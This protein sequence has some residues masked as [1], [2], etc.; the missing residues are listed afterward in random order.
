MLLI[1]D[2]CLRKIIAA[3]APLLFLDYDGTLVGLQ[4]R[5]EGAI[6]RPAKRKLLSELARKIPLAFVSGRS[7]A[8]L[9]EVV[10]IEGVG[11]IGNHGLEIRCLEKDW[12]HP[13]AKSIEP[14]LRDFLKLLMKKAKGL[15]G[16]LLENKGLSGSVHFRC[17]PGGQTRML[18]NLVRSEIEKHS[19]SLRLVS[20]KKVLDVLP[21]VPWDKGRAIIKYI[22][23]LGIHE[24]ITKVYIGDDRTDEDAFK[25]LNSQDIG[26]AVGNRKKT[27]ARFRR[28]DIQGVWNLLFSLNSLL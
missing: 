8:G 14:E 22:S 2:E 27:A 5:P 4:P 17:T 7:L 18:R 9:A 16:V 20:N 3:R 28:R 1:M 11:Y 19:R 21:Q 6:L 23:C 12:V 10:A 15:D 13:R 24:P 26:I 25:I